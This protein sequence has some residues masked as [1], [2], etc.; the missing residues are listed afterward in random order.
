MRAR[1]KRRN[2][3]ISTCDEMRRD[4]PHGLDPFNYE[5]QDLFDCIMNIIG[6]EYL[7]DPEERLAVVAF[8]EGTAAAKKSPWYK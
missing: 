4:N 5:P 2:D 6:T 1:T 7:T 3:I 8:E